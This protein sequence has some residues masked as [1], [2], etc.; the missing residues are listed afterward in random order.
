MRLAVLVVTLGVLLAG[1]ASAGAATPS[2]PVLDPLAMPVLPA[3]GLVIQ[4]PHEVLLVGLD[5]HVFGRLRGFTTTQS[6]GGEL[7][8]D[9][10]SYLPE[11]VFLQ[12]PA[13]RAYV[14]A[15]GRLTP[16][17]PRRFALP[18][19]AELVGGF[20]T[21]GYGT[22][23]SPAAKIWVKDTASGTV[24][25][26]GTDWGIVDGRLLVTGHA[27]IDLVT[28][29][30]WTLGPT[31]R[32]SFA[33][34]TPNRCTPAGIHAGSIEAVCATSVNSHAAGNAGHN[35]VV[36][37]FA[38]SHDGKRDPLG[39]PF[40]YDNFGSADAFLSP[41][42]AHI[43]ATLAVGCGPPYAIIGPTH[44]GKPRYVTGQPD[45][46][47][48]TKAD[49]LGWSR[50]GLAIAEIGAGGCEG[51]HTPGLYLVDPNTFDRTLVFALA[52]S[53]YGYSLWN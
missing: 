16:I 33:E 35:A 50:S 47:I 32:W 13:G 38:V 39:L 27:V 25:A 37:F 48:A 53:D 34:A 11:T 12:G 3:Q 30:R 24:L 46:A 5:G 18:G 2:I 43:A 22:P 6:G 8:T 41:D 45:T 36:R 28:R 15:G 1:L 21:T 31:L 49:M 14:L 9:M 26:G 29:Q 7:L 52:K 51:L 40:L 19:G 23:E 17:S 44:G 20:I 42:G 4:R 10:A